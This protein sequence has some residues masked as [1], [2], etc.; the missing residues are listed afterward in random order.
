MAD[1]DPARRETR[2]EISLKGVI[3]DSEGREMPVVV[4]DVSAHGVRL[5][6]EDELQAGEQ[7]DLSVGK[8]A[9]QPVE[10]VWVRGHE[11]GGVFLKGSGLSS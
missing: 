4:L 8:E 2:I 11:A 1:G 3:R 6:C 5:R 7:V 9:S 10:I